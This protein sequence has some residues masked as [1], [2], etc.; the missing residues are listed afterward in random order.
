MNLPKFV[1]DLGKVGKALYEFGLGPAVR[2][3]FAATAAPPWFPRALT[4]ADGPLQQSA[5]GAMTLA[6]RRSDGLLYACDTGG[7]FAVSGRR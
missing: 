6:L 7:G 5:D 1:G 2:A 4:A 3:D